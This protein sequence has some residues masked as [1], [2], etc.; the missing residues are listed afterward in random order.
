MKKL[1]LLLVLFLAIAI[2]SQAGLW[3]SNSEKE[4][5][6]AFNVIIS[7]NASID[8]YDGSS[9][10]IE[11]GKARLQTGEKTMIASV[12]NGKP[13]VTIINSKGKI[14][15]MNNSC[16]TAVFNYIIVSYVAVD[17]AAGN[18]QAN[19]YLELW[20]RRLDAIEASR[21]ISRR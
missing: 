6:V 19:R 12:S 7:T 17:A 14:I 16:P 2:Q 3:V 10:V 13:L 21:K 5:M 18:P 9:L 8:L 15:P 11:N 4:A 1:F 20:K